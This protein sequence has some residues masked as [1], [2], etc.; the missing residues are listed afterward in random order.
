[1]ILVFASSA[2]AQKT[3]EP[4]DDAAAKIA[5]AISHAKLK[6]VVVFDFPGPDNRLTQLGLDLAAGFRTALA[7]SG[8]KFHV[9]D[10]MQVNEIL[11][12]D[13]YSPTFIFFPDSLLAP[14]Q[15]LGAKAFVSG[16]LSVDGDK[17]VVALSS[18][19]GSDGKGL[20]G[21]RVSWP[22]TENSKAILD[23]NLLAVK[24]TGTSDVPNAGNAGYTTPTCLF[25]PRADYSDA[26][27][28]VRIQGIVELVGTVDTDGRFKDLQIVKPLPYGLNREAMEAIRKWK[29][30]PALGPDGKPAAVRQLVEVSFQL[31]R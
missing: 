29:L 15:D 7:R 8:P 18:Y 30:S 20:R 12:T 28:N 23:K 26:A 24:Q 14:A 25:C 2:T 3:A 1:L 6:T 5:D 19:Q 16:Q 9:E 11:A 31:F 17:V 4:L 10:A 13:S 27:M 22:L 21:L